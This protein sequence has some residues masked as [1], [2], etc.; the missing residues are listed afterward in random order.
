M[1]L[2]SSR[3]SSRSMKWRSWWNNNLD[4]YDGNKDDNDNDDNDMMIDGCDIEHH[5]IISPGTIET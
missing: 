1:T 3:D 4:Y 5:K 2:I